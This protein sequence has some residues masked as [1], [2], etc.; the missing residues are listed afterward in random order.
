MRYL[1][2]AMKP[3]FDI[4]SATDLTPPKEWVDHRALD[5]SEHTAASSV[6]EAAPPPV[7]TLTQDKADTTGEN[8]VEQISDVE[9][10]DKDVDQRHAGD[11]ERSAQATIEAEDGS[12]WKQEITARVN[13]YRT[14][15]P[16][17][18]RYP[19][20][21]LKFEH[22]AQEELSRGPLPIAIN[23]D[24]VAMEPVSRGSTAE[25]TVTETP[26]RIIEFPRANMAPPR[27]LEELAEAV[28]SPPRIL[29]IPEAPTPP[30]ALGGILIES[31]LEEGSIRRPGFEIPL[32]GASMARRILASA[33]DLAIIL[34]NL[35]GFA[36][37]FLRMT[38]EVPS[39][40][41]A[42]AMIGTTGGL[43]WA[44]YQYVFLVYAGSTPGLAL[45]RLRLSC[46]DGRSISR[47]TRRWRALAAILSAMSLG[48]G[49]VW[50]F[51]DEDQLCWHDRITT[52]YV[53]PKAETPKH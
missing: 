21:L 30:P 23:L 37:I 40:L 53:A 18:P 8:T 29:D 5:V 31:H 20:L 13:R 1:K 50:C 45:T 12:A 47:K 14:R 25:P 51:L 15:R 38:H 43:L 26:G 10:R 46:F 48:L 44:G 3:R 9:A 11:R 34:S 49:Y 36:Y 16:R 27:P 19:S 6:Q 42:T 24:A 7:F 52:T 32:R 35:A 28:P 39:A 17:A 4:E 33:L 41:L 22:P 2:K